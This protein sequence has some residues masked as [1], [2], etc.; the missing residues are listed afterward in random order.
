M[1]AMSAPGVGGVYDARDVGRECVRL[2]RK[3]RLGVVK[4][5]G[6]NPGSS[7]HRCGGH[8]T[9]L[10]LGS[11]KKLPNLAAATARYVAHY[12]FCRWHYSLKKTP[13]MAAGLTG[14]SWTMDELL[15][16]AGVV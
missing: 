16:A 12:N 8:G 15:E 5:I 14:H 10:A 1:A 2:Y 4:R 7:H 9:R 3:L 11:S 6:A 13:A